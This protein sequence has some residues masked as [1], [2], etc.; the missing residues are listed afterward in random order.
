MQIYISLI[1]YKLLQRLFE[2]VN[3]SW[4]WNWKF[5]ILFQKYV[6]CALSTHKYATMSECSLSNYPFKQLCLYCLKNIKWSIDKTEACSK[7]STE[8]SFKN[9]GTNAA[10]LSSSPM[11]ENNTVL[12]KNKSDFHYRLLELRKQPLIHSFPRDLLCKNRVNIIK[13]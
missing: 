4:K 13:W 2:S 11:K 1:I 9:E 10:F 12:N 7:V 5:D 3:F 6:F 8:R